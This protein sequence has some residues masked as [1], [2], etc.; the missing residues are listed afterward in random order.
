MLH[1]WEL[2]ILTRRAR[3]QIFATKIIDAITKL[4]NGKEF[5]YFSFFNQTTRC[6]SLF[7]FQYGSDDE[8][9]GQIVTRYSQLKLF[10]E[11]NHN[12]FRYSVFGYGFRKSSIETGKYI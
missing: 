11:M 9:F 10:Y 2:A 6:W 5:R 1:S 7:V 12:N 3:A 8:T 4:Q